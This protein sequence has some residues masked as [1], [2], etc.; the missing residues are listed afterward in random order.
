VIEIHDANPDKK[1]KQ[2]D[3]RYHLLQVSMESV[4]TEMDLVTANI[5]GYDAAKKYLRAGSM[6]QLDTFL[7]THGQSGR[8]YG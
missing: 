5:D 4:D 8:L 7:S 2:L 6:V 1:R 3:Y